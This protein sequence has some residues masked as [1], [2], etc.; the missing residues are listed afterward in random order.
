MPPII[1]APRGVTHLYGGNVV[2]TIDDTGNELVV[3]NIDDTLDGE[4]AVTIKRVVL[5]SN[6]SVP[7]AITHISG[8]STVAVIDD[9]GDELF[10]FDIDATDDDATAVPIKRILLPLN[11][12]APT[13]M[14]LISGGIVVVLDSSGRELL[15][16]DID[17]TP[18]DER[19][20][21]LKR[22]TYPSIIGLSA[23]CTT[24]I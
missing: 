20:V 7:D 6:L 4:E 10:V 19:A 11:L 9:S 1:S 17:A 5:P 12:I 2:A 22:I 13:G 8:G 18:E 21:A 24:I 3:F 23:G 16:F 14:T 15:V